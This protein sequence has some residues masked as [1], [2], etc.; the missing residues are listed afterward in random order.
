[1]SEIMRSVAPF[2]C[3]TTNDAVSLSV[4]FEMKQ[5]GQFMQ[6]R[7]DGWVLEHVVVSTPVGLTH[8]YLHWLRRY[9]ELQSLVTPLEDEVT[10]IVEHSIR[11]PQPSPV[12]SILNVSNDGIGTAVHCASEKNDVMSLRV[13]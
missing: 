12:Q 4:T 8:P 7:I 10:A 6:G 11:P 3:A 2:I 9:I 13:A 1:M 5:S